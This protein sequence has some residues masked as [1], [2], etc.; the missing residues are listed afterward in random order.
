MTKHRLFITLLPFAIASTSSFIV[1]AADKT[2]PRDVAITKTAEAFVEAFHKGDAKTLS[3]FWT[4]NGDY[5]DENGRVLKGRKA[6]EDSFSE[7]FANNKGL[8]LRIDIAARKFPT[9]DT[10]IEDGSS[11]TIAPDGT[12]P[13]RARYTNV[14][15]LKNGKWLLESVREAAYAPPSNYEFL[16]G[17]EWV[18]GEWVDDT[19][20]GAVGRVSFE[21]APAMNFIVATRTVEHRD[22]TLENGTQ[23]I[24]WDPAAKQIRSW[25]FE[26]DG[27][28]GEGTWSKNGNKW[29]IKTSS[30]LANGSK[31]TTT[32]VVTR[33]DADTITW[34]S[35]DQKMDGNA[36]PDSAEITMK[37]TD[38]RHST[39][40]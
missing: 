11:A 34:K 32:N 39:D 8:K 40:Y 15:I 18:I 36:L 24:G 5:V 26:A 4:E 14:M 3:E 31:V 19:A 22:A 2:D 6:I 1:R 16:R 17:L 25:S 13:S 9:P 33:V 21:W 28:F 38:D 12:A 20:G 35:T 37:R 7:F 27:G 23:W 29:I 10:A 30:S